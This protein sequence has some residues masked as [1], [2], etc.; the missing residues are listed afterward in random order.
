MTATFAS[1]PGGMPLP[2]GP[3]GAVL[4]A[5][6]LR[7]CFVTPH[8][9]HLLAV[10]DVSLSVPAGRMLGIVGE[11]GS[12]KTTV[13]RCLAG[14]LRPDSG[15]I[16]LSGEVL[17]GRRSPAQRR[18]VQLVFQDPY[19]SL[20][21]RL[22]VGTVLR[23]LLAEH[24]IARGEAAEAR[25]RQL[26]TLVGLGEAALGGYPSAFS[27]GQR[28]RIAIARALAVE[29]AVLVA[30]EPVSSLDVSVQ[31]TILA[32]FA[33][34]RDR[35]GLAVV[36]ISHNLAAVR[37]VCDDVAVMYLGRIVEQGSREAVFGD[38]RHPY[39]RALL[40]AA[41]RLRPGSEPVAA[42]LAGE[43]PSATSRPAG[44]AFHPRCPRA[45]ARC[46][47]E[48]PRL[49]PVTPAAAPAATGASAEV[50][51]DPV[52]HPAL[53]AHPAHAAA[54]HFRDERPREDRPRE[55]RP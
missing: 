29:P 4:G 55:D 48:E 49:L 45:E 35:L 38:P 16:V 33:E 24:G 31:A 9:G 19:A 41:P 46:A 17:T 14:L 43:P 26:M 13:A 52:A 50:A 11:S 28:Q 15:E 37:N 34:L 12:G 51:S 21:P 32:L 2:Q 3:S 7:V 1:A 42:R 53:A 5:A 20:N 10:D 44:C 18:A 40:A 39:T 30:D 36:M 8:A 25:C 6:G 27:G 22:R 54:C 23:E 47:V